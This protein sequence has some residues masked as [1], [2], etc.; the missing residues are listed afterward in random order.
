M[1]SSFFADCVLPSRTSVLPN[2]AVS[3]TCTRWNS[4]LE[5]KVSFFNALLIANS[6]V[7]HS[8]NLHGAVGHQ[9]GGG[10]SCGATQRSSGP[11]R[12]TTAHQNALVIS[13]SARSASAMAAAVARGA[14][15]ECRPRAPAPRQLTPAA[16]LQAAESMRRREMGAV[17][18]LTGP[19]G[20]T[21]ALLPTGTEPAMGRLGG[22][23][24]PGEHGVEG[25]TSPDLTT[26]GRLATFRRVPSST[27]PPL[28]S[29][30]TRRPRAGSRP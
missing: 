20:R 29:A 9:S 17:S 14:G 2:G 12:P 24:L 26:G 23:C 21:G 27:L 19:R 1:C 6:G 22:P 7:I 28:Q 8:W 5:S 15:R 3:T 16:W 30:C 25:A 11:A 10:R 13:G 18:A 4:D